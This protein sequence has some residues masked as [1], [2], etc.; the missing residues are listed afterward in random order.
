MQRHCRVSAVG[1]V[2]G[3]CLGAPDRGRDTNPLV[4]SEIPTIDTESTHVNRLLT[5][6][7]G[8]GRLLLLY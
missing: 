3:A 6:V 8:E 1:P 4:W 7:V 5:H 2:G